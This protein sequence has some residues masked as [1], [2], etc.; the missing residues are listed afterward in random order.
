[1]AAQSTSSDEALPADVGEEAPKPKKT[2][3]G[4]S[5]SKWRERTDAASGAVVWVH[6]DTGRARWTKPADDDDGGVPVLT[7]ERN[8][9]RERRANRSIVQSFN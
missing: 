3:R 9:A 1:M 7:G 8:Q 6:A 5:T 2:K 4:A